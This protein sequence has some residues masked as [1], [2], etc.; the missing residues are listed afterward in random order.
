MKNI[1]AILIIIVL[2]IGAYA[3]SLSNEFVWDDK[4]LVEDN[5]RIEEFSGIGKVFTEELY[6]KSSIPLGYY[7]P[8]Q[9]IS[10]MLDNFMWGKEP[11][12][13]HLTSIFFQIINSIFVFYLCFLLLGDKLKSLFIASVF[14]VHPAFVPVVSYISGRADLLGL[15]FSLITIYCSLQYINSRNITTLMIAIAS[16]ALAVVSK[17]Y[18]LITPLFI[19]FYVWS[20]NRAETHRSSA[21]KIVIPLI[22]IAAVYLGL[23]L[24][25]LNFHQDMGDLAAL[26]LSTRMMLFPYLLTKYIIT[27]LFPVNLGMEKKLIYS[28]L[29]EARFLISYITP[30]TLAGLLCFFH[31]IKEKKG[32]FFTGWFIIGVLPV[33]NL[34]MPLKIFMADHWIYMASIGL[35]ATCTIL[36][37]V[38]AAGAKL[39]TILAKRL[40]VSIGTVI[41]AGLVLLTIRENGYW[42]NEETLFAHTISKSPGSAR[43]YYNMA[44]VQ[45][46]KGDIT[47]ALEYYTIA[48]DKSNGRPQYLRSRAHIYRKMGDKKKALAD[49][50]RAAENAPD[51]AGYQNDLGAMYAELGM[52][53]EAKEAWRRSLELDPDNDF[54]RRNLKLISGSRR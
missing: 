30:L 6:H 47:K 13:Y 23:R 9:T 54:T 25:V 49:F 35:V 22:V 20:L 44:K 45:E 50:K 16:Y 51:V 46:E 12:G 48:V 33:S 24:T 29:S 1:T 28:T 31:N 38:L 4:I 32:I 3:N 39:D 27:I 21:R 40:K 5:V 42:K 8:L 53:Q 41:V 11:F 26:P 14:C 52:I 37:D 43:T 10:Y 15:M 7:R 17:E 18:Y 2:G 34:F 19:A 36:A